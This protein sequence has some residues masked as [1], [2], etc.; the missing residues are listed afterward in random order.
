M[1]ES[2][3]ALD[4]KTEKADAH[5]ICGNIYLLTGELSNALNHFT[6]GLTIFEKLNILLLLLNFFQE[7]LSI[8]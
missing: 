1:D 8:R 6:D 4:F 5:V 2:T 7:V 3:N